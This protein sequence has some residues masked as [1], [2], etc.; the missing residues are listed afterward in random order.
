MFTTTDMDKGRLLNKIKSYAP[1]S[2]STCI[3]GFLQ[4][5]PS[6]LCLWR[7][8]YFWAWKL[9]S[10]KGESVEL[11]RVNAGQPAAAQ[12][13]LEDDT[14]GQLVFAFSYPLAC[15]A[16]IK[17]RLV[18]VQTLRETMFNIL[19]HI[20]TS[21]CAFRHCFYSRFKFGVLAEND[22]SKRL[23]N[24]A[25]KGKAINSTKS[26]WHWVDSQRSQEPVMTHCHCSNAVGL[27]QRSQRG[28]LWAR[29]FKHAMRHSGFVFLRKKDG[30]RKIH[31]LSSFSM[32]L[33]MIIVS[34]AHR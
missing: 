27:P 11:I 10:I 13:R 8:D 26:S 4:Q 18:G 32:H 17:L 16:L 14:S 7:S 31:G 20:S 1:F 23:I 25:T 15:F 21:C 9:P 5:A 29:R 22:T 19:E 3:L 12:R 33:L 30:F 6:S 34:E 24:V 2:Q 28:S